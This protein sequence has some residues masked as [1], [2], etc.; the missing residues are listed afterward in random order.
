MYIILTQLVKYFGPLYETSK[1]LHEYSL[2]DLKRVIYKTNI[3]Y[4]TNM[5]LKVVCM[6]YMYVY[7]IY[8]YICMYLCI[9]IRHNANMQALQNI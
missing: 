4:F 3:T 7:L 5:M 9:S 6:H 1:A 8:I 2:W